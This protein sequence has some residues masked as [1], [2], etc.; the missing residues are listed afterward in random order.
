MQENKKGRRGSVKCMEV[1]RNSCRNVVGKP[2]GK[3]PFE[4]T[5]LRREGNI[6][7]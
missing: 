4:R 2:E 6:K 5:R 1:R 7:M 3:I